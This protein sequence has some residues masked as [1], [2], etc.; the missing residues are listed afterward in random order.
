V[1]SAVRE[2]C[3]AKKPRWEFVRRKLGQPGIWD[4]LRAKVAAE[5]KPPETIHSWLA[6]AGGATAPAD[7]GCS[8]GRIRAA[9]LHMHEIRKRLTIIDLAWLA[10]V[11]PAAVDDIIDQWLSGSARP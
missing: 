3:E 5:V 9:I 7:I 10:G 4:Q 11:M 6:R 8:R 2:Q 1:A